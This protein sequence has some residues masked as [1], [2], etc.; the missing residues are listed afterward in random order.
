MVFIIHNG[1]FTLKFKI[2]KTK[3]KQRLL[4]VGLIL[5]FGYVSTAFSADLNDINATQDELT[6]F[7]EK[8]LKDKLHTESNNSIAKTIKMSDIAKQKNDANIT[9]Q[10][11]DTNQSREVFKLKESKEAKNIDTIVGDKAFIDKVKD[12]KKYILENYKIGGQKMEATPELDKKLAT[13]VTTSTNGNEKI[14]IV[15]SS[16]MPDEQIRE[17]FKAVEGKDN[18]K[19]ILRGLVGDLQKFDPTRKYLERLLKKNPNDKYS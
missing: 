2:D 7:N 1:R 17:Y 12:N 5:F 3:L 15:I 16:S 9:F 8:Y 10:K 19:F 14:F 13:E 11:L 18:I 6:K 4:F